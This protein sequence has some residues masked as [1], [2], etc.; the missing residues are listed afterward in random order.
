MWR[1]DQKI[2]HSSNKYQLRQDGAVVELVI[3]KLQEADSGEYSCD[4][5]Y[6]TTSAQLTVKGRNQYSTFF[7]GVSAI[8]CSTSIP[9]Q[10]LHGS[11]HIFHIFLTSPFYNSET[12]HSIFPTEPSFSFS[13]LLAWDTLLMVY[14]TN[15]TTYHQICGCMIPL[16]WCDCK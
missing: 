7:T 10:L 15:F 14:T 11:T 1:K 6:E 8:K 4:S 16:F 2:L 9:C 3:Y 13:F 5:G 12:L